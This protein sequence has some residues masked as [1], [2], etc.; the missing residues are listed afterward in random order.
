MGRCRREDGRQPFLPY[1]LLLYILLTFARASA[2]D[3]NICDSAITV[4]GVR[5][6]LQQLAGQHSA[7][8]TENTPPSQNEHVITF[9]ICKDLEKSSIPE[10]DQVR[11]SCVFGIVCYALY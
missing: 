3:A 8:Y 10:S 6:N 9:D 5:Y 4:D 2:Q 11:V 1:T 7:K